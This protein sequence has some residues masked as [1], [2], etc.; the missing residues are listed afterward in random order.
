[1]YLE[2]VELGTPYPDVVEHVSGLVADD[3]LAGCT[4][5]VDATGVGAPVVDLLKKAKLPCRLMPVMITGGS[6]DTPGRRAGTM[7]LGGSC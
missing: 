2:R 3:R 6:N 1:M 4:L 5:V 7:C